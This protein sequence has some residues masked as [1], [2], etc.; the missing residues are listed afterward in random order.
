MQY[1]VYIYILA[2]IVNGVDQ[3]CK[4]TDTVPEVFTAD[5]II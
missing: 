4:A 3:P 5:D 1:P 2:V